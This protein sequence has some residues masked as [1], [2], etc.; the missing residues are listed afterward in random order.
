MLGSGPDSPARPTGRGRLLR[1]AKSRAFIAVVLVILGLAAVNAA[2]VAAIAATSHPR[3][4]NWPAPGYVFW[5]LRSWRTVERRLDE[6]PRSAR[7]TRGVLATVTYRGVTL[8]IPVLHVRAAGATGRPLKVLLVSGVHG[9]ETSGVEALLSLAADL[10]RDPAALPGAEMDIVPVANP[11]GWVYGYRYNGDG[12]DMN[13]DFA[14]RRTLEAEAIRGL[15]SRNGPY[16]LVMDLHESKKYGYFVYQYLPHGPGLG[17]EYA[18]ILRDLGKPAQENYREGLFRTRGGVLRIPVVALP[19]IA[20]ARQLSLEH[21][22][23]LHGTP[24]SYTIETPLWDEFDDRV[25]VHRR[26]VSSF[27]A[28]VVAERQSPAGLGR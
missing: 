2:V 18:R 10:A 8:P 3:A 9:T 15:V 6:L 5:P 7:L 14:S 12:E 24:H 27:V 23:R 20:A 26:A 11:W 21:Y 17:E 22:T 1:I 16:D 4:T 28:A 19:W 13:R 25:R